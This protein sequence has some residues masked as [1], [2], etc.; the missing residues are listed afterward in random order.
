[1]NS[2]TERWRPVTP[3]LA[4]LARRYA[5]TVA[6]RD[7]LP[8]DA[9]PGGGPRQSLERASLGIEATALAHRLAAEV[10]AAMGAGR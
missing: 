10:V 8:L 1:M 3:T 6:A 7:G 2:F 9:A 5:A 4:D